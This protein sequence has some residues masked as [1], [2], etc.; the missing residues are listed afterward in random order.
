MCACACGARYEC[1]DP[2][3]VNGDCPE[4]VAIAGEPEP[5]PDP[6]FDEWAEAFGPLRRTGAR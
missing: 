2:A 1:G 3:C 6:E 5:E 4:C